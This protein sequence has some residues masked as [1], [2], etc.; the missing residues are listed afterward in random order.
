VELRALMSAACAR[1]LAVSVLCFALVE[2]ATPEP[3]HRLEPSGFLGDYAQLE[4]RLGDQP[5]FL[6]IAPGANFSDYSRVQIEPVTVWR[7][8]GANLR[9]VPEAEAVR[10]ARYFDAALRREL[11]HDFEVVATPSPGTLRLRAAITEARA[12][13][14]ALDLPASTAES[15]G[16]TVTLG[17]GAATLAEGTHAVVGSAAIELELLD[18]ETGRRLAAAV[19]EGVAQ[20]AGGAA[21]AW[22]DVEAIFD[23]WAAV[24][25]T[26]LAILRN[27][28]AVERRRDQAEPTDDQPPG[29]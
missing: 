15:S 16:S 18:A 9:D 20:R 10:L 22:Q 4:P 12:A 28:D 29:S 2:C 26:R 3:A 27:T 1:L 5:A 21:D 11:A 19:D 8:S 7:K 17:A 14:V 13:P 23:R 25:A 24:I 6:Y